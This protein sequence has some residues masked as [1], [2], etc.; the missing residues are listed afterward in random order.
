[1]NLNHLLIWMSARGEGSW[2]QFRSAVEQFHGDSPESL[3]NGDAG[4]DVTVGDLPVYQTVRLALERLAHVEFSSAGSARR[5]R[6]VPPA[7]ALSGQGAQ[8]IGVLCGARPPALMEELDRLPGALVRDVQV[9]PGLPDRVRLLA[10]TQEVLYQASEL[11]GLLAQRD[12]PSALLAAI[13]PVD[14]PR[15]RHPSKAPLVPGWTIHRFVPA[16]LKWEIARY[17]DVPEAKTGLFRFVMR[18][19]RFHYLQWRGETFWVPV[20]V[21]KYA[22]LRRKRIRGIVWYDQARAVLAVPL[23]CRPPLLI[24][25]ALVLC[26][27]F[28]PRFDRTTGRLEYSEVPP[29]VAQLAAELLRQRV[30]TR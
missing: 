4:D 30:E 18:Y 22:I 20:Q 23:T 3:D 16:T 24:E 27:G 10:S 2:Q 6:I 5:W 14:D 17:Q 15:S 7:L 25:R 1:M 29:G 12:A 9:I 13:P 19:Q 26:S 8:W 11:L 28:L 21:G